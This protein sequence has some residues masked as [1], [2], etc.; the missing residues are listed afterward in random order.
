MILT[1]MKITEAPEELVVELSARYIHLYE[2]I[3]G[4][5]FNFLTPSNPFRIGST[6]TLKVFI[7]KYESRNHYGIGKHESHAKKITDNLDNLNISWEQFVVSAH[8]QPLEAA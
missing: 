7:K 4:E 5:N 6:I 3:T 2:T 1:T 8:K